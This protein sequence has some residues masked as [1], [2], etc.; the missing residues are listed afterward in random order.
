[1]IN[2]RMSS[3]SFVA[4]HDDEEPPRRRSQRSPKT[5]RSVGKA[6]LTNAHTLQDA[7]S[8]GKNQAAYFIT[9]RATR[10]ITIENVFF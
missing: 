5:I 7:T 6:P 8:D 3:L 4:D 2:G 1:M 9:C 10:G